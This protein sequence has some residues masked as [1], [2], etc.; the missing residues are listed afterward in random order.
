MEIGHQRMCLK[1]EEQLEILILFFLKLSE[2]EIINLPNPSQSYKN[3]NRLVL[4]L[5]RFR[6][7]HIKYTKIRI[8]LIQKYEAAI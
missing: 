2:D 6:N 7:I 5:Y 3:I 4:L 8:K 1:G